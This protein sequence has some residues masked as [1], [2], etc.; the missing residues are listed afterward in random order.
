MCAPCCC[1]IGDAASVRKGSPCGYL[2][3]QRGLGGRC[4]S[5]GCLQ[6]SP[7]PRSDK[8]LLMGGPVLPLVCRCCVSGV[9][10]LHPCGISVVLHWRGVVA[11][12]LLHHHRRCQ[13]L[14]RLSSMQ[15]LFPEGGVETEQSDNGFRGA[16]PDGQRR[17]PSLTHAPRRLAPPNTVAVGHAIN[18]PAHNT[19]QEP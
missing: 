11:S 14:S 8:L 18:T 2:V 13:H 16:L 4:C 3:L 5:G 19:T 7:T 12:S 6:C 10:P 17:P 9:P 15:S 1:G